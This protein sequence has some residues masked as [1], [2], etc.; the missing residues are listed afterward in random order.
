MFATGFALLGFWISA[1]LSG[2]PRTAAFAISWTV[3][4]NGGWK[5]M[6]GDEHGGTWAPRWVVPAAAIGVTALN[7]SLYLIHPVFAP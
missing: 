1:L 4:V 3:L 5:V 7:V 2:H 6:H